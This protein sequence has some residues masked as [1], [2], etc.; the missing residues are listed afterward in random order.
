MTRA[1]KISGSTVAIG[2]RTHGVAALFR[3]NARGQTM[4][5]I[6]RDGKG[7]AQRGLVVRHHQLKVQ[8]ARLISAEWSADDPGRIANNERHLVGRAM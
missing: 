6:D 1:H 5:D 4:A 7:S 2:K 3:R 8:P